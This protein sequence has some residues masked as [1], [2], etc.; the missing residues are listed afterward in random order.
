MTEEYSNLIMQFLNCDCELFSN[1]RTQEEIVTRFNE[2]TEQGEI[3]GYYPLI[4]IVSD[5]LEELFEILMEG[6]NIE[7]TP[8]GIAAYRQNIIDTA[9]KIDAEMLLSIRLNKIQES[10][11]NANYDILGQFV[12]AESVNEINLHMRLSELSGEVVIAKIPTKN[13]WELAAWIPMGGVNE[14][15]APV[16]QVAVFRYWYEKY[17]AVPSVVAYDS[18]QLAQIKQ[19]LSNEEAESLAKEQFAFCN[20]IV[21]QWAKSIRELASILKNSGVWFFWWD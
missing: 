20:D 15:P 19:P 5:I 18:W 8:E 4:V 3:D 1:D 13:P 6:N 9:N 16:E 2:L 10:L 7:D 17:G 11:N 12:S 21:S 14:C